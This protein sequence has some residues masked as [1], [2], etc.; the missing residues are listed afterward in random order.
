MRCGLLI[1]RPLHP[2]TPA[3]RAP[4]SPGLK[5]QLP[6]STAAVLTVCGLARP[7]IVGSAPRAGAWLTWLLRRPVPA[8]AGL[9]PGRAGTLTRRELLRPGP[10]SQECPC[11]C[12]V[13]GGCPSCPAH[14]G[15]RPS[16]TSS[17]LR[18][19]VRDPA[20]LSPAP[21]RTSS[22]WDWIAQAQS[23]QGS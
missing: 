22:G 20:N 14:L 5:G 16:W 11:N 13:A 7:E 10:K 2:T 3:A 9:D 6:S 1:Y 4:R 17:D 19:V 21:L 8:R 18:G 12:S 23:L 15:L